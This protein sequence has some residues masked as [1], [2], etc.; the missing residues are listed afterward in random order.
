V[1]RE[2]NA[3]RGSATT[4][5]PSA[6]DDADVKAAVCESDPSCEVVGILPASDD[7]R[8]GR[9]V[10]VE[11][12][13]GTFDRHGYVDLRATGT[14]LLGGDAGAVHRVQLLDEHCEPTGKPRIAVLG[15]GR[16]RQI[17]TRT[18]SDAGAPETWTVS[19]FAIDPP[20]LLRKTYASSSDSGELY[21]DTWDSE[22]ARGGTCTR[23]AP[24]APCT[25][26]ALAFPVLTVAD[27][28]FAVGS[29]R[30]TSLGDCGLYVDGSPGNGLI[31]PPEGAAPGTVVRALVSDDAM[32]VEISDDAF[33]VAGKV[34]DRLDVT[35]TSRE[36]SPGEPQSWQLFMDGRVTSIEGRAPKAEMVSVDSTLRRFKLSGVAVAWREVA[37]LSYTDTAD[38]I[39]TRV[40]LRSGTV[41]GEIHRVPPDSAVCTPEG[42][43]LRVRRRGPPPAPT[44]PL[45]R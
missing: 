11:H 44:E 38:G 6:R 23:S 37:S 34:V 42:G 20:R 33:V 17:E 27:P 14:W 16:I 26:R 25:T 32:Y 3:A 9:I 24:D 43:S 1:I 13:C 40:V 7:L 31:E 45:P 8:G 21:E 18:I 30:A 10:V 28:A 12:S 35:L 19:D 36:A 41:P 5:P 22:A 15:P 39:A 4:A 29:W 2:V